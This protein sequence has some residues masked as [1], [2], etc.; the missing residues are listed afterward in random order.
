MDYFAPTESLQTFINLVA[1]GGF[2][3][4]PGILLGILL[5]KLAT[6]RRAHQEEFSYWWQKNQELRSAR[7]C[8][9]D[10]WVFGGGLDGHPE[11]YI[12]KLWARE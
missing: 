7:Y 3:L 8:S 12:D 1:T 11:D 2:A 4:L 6:Y 5:R 10:D 9:R